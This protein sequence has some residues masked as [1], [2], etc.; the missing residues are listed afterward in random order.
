M[1]KVTPRC[2][3]EFKFDK[4]KGGSDRFDK[5]PEEHSCRV[6]INFLY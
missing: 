4:E 6:P 5:N 3:V 1:S 2:C